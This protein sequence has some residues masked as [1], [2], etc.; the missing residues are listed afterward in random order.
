MKNS[1]TGARDARDVRTF[2]RAKFSSSRYRTATTANPYVSRLTYTLMEFRSYRVQA[3][4]NRITHTWKHFPSEESP[5]AYDSSLYGEKS[6]FARE[7]REAFEILPERERDL[8]L[9]R[10]ENRS[11]S[12]LTFSLVQI[13]F[14]SYRKRF[15]CFYFE[16]AIVIF[17][18]NLS[19]RS[20]SKRV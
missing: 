5:R 14:R 16:F 11:P 3:V 1:V 9:R 4:S 2:V 20:L 18:R 6:V 19:E 12:R 17:I 8:A 15:S 10:M 7:V 13:T